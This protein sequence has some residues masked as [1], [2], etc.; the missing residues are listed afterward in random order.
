MTLLAVT[1]A[2]TPVVAAA[3]G[4]KPAQ[5]PAT[6][7]GVAAP[8]DPADPGRLAYT[9]YGT[10]RSLGTIV[11]GQPPRRLLPVG[12]AG[13]NDCQATA[14]GDDTVFV[15][16]RNGEDEG[17]FRRTGDGPPRLV[18]QRKGWRI[19]DPVLSPDRTKIAFVSWQDGFVDNYDCDDTRRFP[20]TG[21]TVGVWVVGT[22]GQG[23]R[24][25]VKNADWA[26]W[27]P[28]GS[29]F[30]FTRD[31]KA[32]RV[33]VAGGTETKVSYG[34]EKAYKPVWEPS[35]AAGRNRVAY[36]T[37]L[38][39]RYDQALATVFATD[40]GSRPSRVLA[41]GDQ[42]RW[43][44]KG[45]AWSP[46]GRQLAFL[47]GE[48]YLVDA[49]RDPC[50]TCG[51]GTPLFPD[52]VRDFDTETV[53]WYTPAG[54][55]PVVLIG[56]TD[57]EY[58]ALDESRAAAPY[59]RTELRAGKTTETDLSDAAYAPDGTRMAF[60]RSTENSYEY[61]VERVLVGDTG[62]LS[63]AVP[64]KYDRE[65]DGE[66]H[67]SRPAWSP[68]GTR[69][70]FSRWL[71]TYEEDPESDRVRRIVGD[72]RIAVV[73]VS[74]GI[75]DGRLLYLVAERRE[76]ELN[77]YSD[78]R[79]P[80]WS[81]DGRTLAF[82]RASDCWSPITSDGG[83]DR[84]ARA[85]NPYEERH[86]WKAEA[87]DGGATADLTR[88]QCDSQWCG[89]IDLRPAFRPGTH[90]IAF[91]RHQVLSGPGLTSRPATEGGAAAPATSATAAAPATS[92]TAAAPVAPA[93]PAAA[94]PPSVAVVPGGY[95]GPSIVL[96][97]RDDDPTECRSLVPAGIGCPTTV[98]GGD[99]E[100]TP[101]F[102]WPDNPAWT[103]DGSRFAIDFRVDG[104]EGTDD[105]R[106][107]VFDA[108][109]SDGTE[110]RARWN[111][112]QAT[113]TWKPSADLRTYLTTSDS[114]L[115]LG[116]T[117]TLTLV[118]WN[119]GIAHAPRVRAQFTLPPGLEAVGPPEPSTGTGLAPGTC[120]ADLTCVF[121]PVP[122]GQKGRATLRVKGVATGEQ[123]ATVTASSAL[124]DHLPG[125]NS[126]EAVINVVVPD[127]AVTAT[128]T[129][130][131]INI[132]E[133]STVEFTV[134]NGG[135][136]AA[137]DVL[138]K[139][140]VPPGLTLVSGTECPPA[141]CAL[142]TVEPG[143]EQK[144][145]L[146][147][148]AENAFSGAIEGTVSASTPDNNPENDRASV[149]LTVVDPRLPDPAVT[150][151]A[152]PAVIRTGFLSDVVYTVR[153]LG[154][155]PARAVTLTTL[156]PPGMRVVSATPACPDTGCALGDLAP[157][158]SVTV[159]RKATSD[160]PLV[161]EAVGTVTTPGADS[162]PGN[163]TA[164]A[165]ITVLKRD[166]T[167][168]DNPTPPRLR[169]DPSVTVDA[170]P[171]TAYTGGRISARIVVRNEGVA[172]ATGLRLV[173]AVPRGVGVVSVSKPQCLTPAGCPLPDLRSV[174]RTDVRLV[175]GANSGLTGAITATVSTTGT[176]SRPAN[177]TARAPL[178][179]KEPTL[180]LIPPL[181]PPGSVTQASGTQFPPGATLRLRWSR[182]VTVA[183]AP[184][185]VRADGTFSA[186][187]L[188]LVQDTLGER[189]LRV[190]QAGVRTPLFREL[191]APY[192]VVPGVLQPS[193]FQWRR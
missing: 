142:G 156:L 101:D 65:L 90:E 74:R 93:P 33:P 108:D 95:D 177:N 88:N 4:G 125:D 167:P 103:P 171:R 1:P 14:R 98:P 192:L 82:S 128:A 66:E 166:S 54:G 41:V 118:V 55:E 21:S 70:A 49:D 180:T 3:S 178:T 174:D 35:D 135:T 86:I 60:V 94:A 2:G 120:A 157:G 122:S 138:L 51:A 136:A 40:G 50:T 121:D 73:D 22:D 146:V 158:A 129:P 87:R 140:V 89:V 150:V 137:R 165:P 113:P 160:A 111:S 20:L 76:S 104:E 11:R 164:A 176:D 170:T 184:V 175:L 79:D 38:G 53:G 159:T 56:G 19:A 92:A 84:L 81:S 80:T 91:T 59:D 181:G 34:D 100:G 183:S 78:D 30:V 52:G 169:A 141:G 123:R 106:I 15:S 139:L 144:L 77:C 155:A 124:P 83:S 148:T 7:P 133:R 97:L 71:V 109:G 29:Q 130:P 10:H 85:V 107:A 162:N 168:P 153:N 152:T 154:D 72:A 187:M 47:T 188:I 190:A 69:V 43:Q 110:L 62:R 12:Q 13:R 127:L 39:D 163:N 18:L 189:E 99:G 67:Q 185:V 193:D 105:F 114:P 143:A 8:E 145:T 134:R 102:E 172:R 117:G 68:D 6:A 173:V 191:T 149:D 16:M 23:L 119:L 25:A 24:E 126:A 42:G 147:Y 9:D 64:L 131:V 31:E 75:E 112:E 45:A 48:P 186:P 151:T 27:S 63:E 161:G 132:R 182:G 116:Q 46:D 28:D 115:L 5:A 57:P 58:F 179:V 37:E 44:R 96:D 17:L 32:Y 61:E 36:V 26:D